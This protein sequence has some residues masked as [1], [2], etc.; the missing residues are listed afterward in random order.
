M[1]R[2]VGRD[3]DPSTM[4]Q[5]PAMGFD[6]HAVITLKKAPSEALMT[7]LDHRFGIATH[8]VGTKTVNITEHVSVSDAADAMAFVRS[9]VEDAMPQGAVISELNAATDAG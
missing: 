5:T 8:E 3:R 4:V 2:Q 6:V 9:L 7:E 1:P